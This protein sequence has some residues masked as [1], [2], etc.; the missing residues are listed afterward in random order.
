[1]HFVVKIHFK[2]QKM[3]ICIN[4]CKI[5]K[6]WSKIDCQEN[7]KYKLIQSISKF[8]TKKTSHKN[9]YYWYGNKKNFVISNALK[10]AYF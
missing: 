7:S 4:A 9:N 8:A 2:K 5:I 10:F 3:Q 1:M 6:E